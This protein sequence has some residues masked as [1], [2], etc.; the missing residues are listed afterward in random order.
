MKILVS[1]IQRYSI[2]DG[3]GIRTTIFLKGCNFRCKWCHNPE[4]LEKKILLGVDETKCSGCCFCVS[5]CPQHAISFD[6]K[7][8]IDR[9]K[10]NNCGAC[11]AECFY[12]VFSLSGKW[13]ELD[14]LVNKVLEDQVYFKNSS[15]GV[16]ISGGEPFVQGEAVVS[17]ASLFHAQRIHT[18]I[19]TNLSLPFEGW[20]KKSLPYVD[21]F[22]VDLKLLNEEKH[23]YWTSSD[24]KT[25]LENIKKL[26]KTGKPFEVRTPVIAGV[27]DTKEEI[28]GI[29]SWLKSLQNMTRFTLIG[30][31]PLGL[32]KYIRFGI[33][34]D[35]TSQACFPS[36]RLE[37]LQVLANEELE[38]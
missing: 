13:F 25:V 35:Y 27:N 32:A 17:L 37:E 6:K 20:I 3:P 19:Q 28:S 4:S 10:C 31:H 8:Q 30:Y 21:A 2:E 12:N 9:K 33:H 22:M 29:A 18:I 38:K 26:D 24:N 5:I 7:L 15:G 16:T 14:E 1:N 36:K 34:C 23:T 11:V